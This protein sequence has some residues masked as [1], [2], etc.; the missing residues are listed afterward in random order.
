MANVFRTPTDAF[1]FYYDTIHKHGVDHCNCKAIFNE[2]FWIEKPLQNRITT[3]F[4]KWSSKYAEREWNWY[5]TGDPGGNEISKH[6]PIWF[7]H[8]DENGEV[9]SNYGHQWQ[10]NDQ[11]GYVIKELERDPQSRRAGLTFY[12]G[13][14]HE[15]YAY[16][17]PCTTGAFFYINNGKLDMTITMRSN[18]LWFGFCNDQYCFSELQRMVADR[19][20]LPVGQYFHFAMN[21]HLY[22]DFLNRN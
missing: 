9:R 8:M 4:R 5:L 19:L 14:E 12:D 10:R 16:D 11:I 13:K 7:N 15:T 22:P 20:N 6:A 18:D 1:E 2:G 17:T 21:F 3:P